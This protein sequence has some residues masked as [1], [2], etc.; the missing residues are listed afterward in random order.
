M[1]ESTG[2][3]TLDPTPHRRQQARQQGHVARSADLC[4][5]GVLLLGLATLMTLGGGLA[6]FVI[7]YSRQQ[8]GGDASLTPSADFA[9]HHGVALL[10]NLGRHLLPI[11]GFLC[12]A[13]IAVNV[14]QIGFLFL[15]ERL[16]MDLSR[17]DPFQGV[18]R[19]F[20]LN[21]G[22]RLGFSLMKTVIVLVVAGIVI[23]GQRHSIVRL[24]QLPAPQLALQMTQILTGTAFRVGGVLLV[25]ALLD[26]AFQWWKHEQ[27][28]KM[29]PQELR[30]ELR[31]LEGNPQVIARR[32]QM[33][34]ELGVN[35]LA[36]S[37]PRADVVLTDP[38]GLAV[39]V[40]YDPDTMTAPT[41]M[42]KGAGPLGKR[43]R[44][45]A[46]QRRIAVV[47]T[48]ALTQWLY[49][50][51]AVNRVVPNERYNAVAEVLMEVYQRN[52]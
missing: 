41:I 12:L 48:P 20:S 49:R 7:E 32:K 10:W 2:D 36:A 51:V 1:P 18:Q 46:A 23:Y 33:Q 6:N 50:N 30:E 35:R 29:T 27:D 44:E 8:L 24:A 15:P 21:N 19:I 11:L 45:S 34:R 38:A 25:L 3:K 39:A 5:A 52:E 4:S 28:L 13:G 47:E 31:N 37:V 16:T 9:I 42:A 26:Y 17:I 14:I 22:I 43:I 40:R